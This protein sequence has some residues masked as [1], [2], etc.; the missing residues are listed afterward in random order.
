M[1]RLIP[2][3]VIWL[4]VSG[5]SSADGA[6]SGAATGSGGR[7]S[8]FAVIVCKSNERSSV[9]HTSKGVDMPDDPPI[10]ITREGQMATITLNRPHV[11]NV[12]NLPA[13]ELLQVE[14]DALAADPP[15]VVIV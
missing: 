5:V 12:L 8:R 1:R 13:L 14:L 4:R 3:C 6:A 10:L 2:R 15:R 9:R 11:R 7:R